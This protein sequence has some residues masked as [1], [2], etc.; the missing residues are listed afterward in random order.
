[1]LVATLIAP[2]AAFAQGR[3]DA[4]VEPVVVTTTA[5]RIRTAPSSIAL[6]T[7]EYGP[8]TQFRLAPSDYQLKD[9]YAIEY[10]G[11]VL[12][13][14]RYAAVMKGR[15]AMPAMMPAPAP[16]QNV[17]QAGAPVVMPA[18]APAVMPAPPAR[19]AQPAPEA[20]QPVIAE[21]IQM[22]EKVERPEILIGATYKI[23]S[24]LF[25]HALYVT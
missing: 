7:D 13:V 19:T 2:A 15:A 5:V 1:M 21:V 17:V 24:P 4:R 14:P 8:G 16:V 18:A 12:Y 10:D 11:R 20:P 6:S 22:H 23:K 3:A 25:E 9:W